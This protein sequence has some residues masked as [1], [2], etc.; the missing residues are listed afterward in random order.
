MFLTQMP[1]NPQ[2]RTTRELVSSPQRMHAAV[3]SGFLPGTAERERVLWRLDESDR[4]TLNLFIVSATEPSLEAM[5]EQAGWQTQPVWRSADYRRFLERLEGGQRWVFRLRANPVISVRPANGGRG[6]RVPLARVT[7]QEAWLLE[8]APRLGFTV[9]EGDQGRPNLQVSDR[10]RDAFRRG[11]GPDARTVTLATARFDGVLEV[12]D[13]SALR[14]T[15]VQ[16]VGS[17]KGYGCGL[18][19]LA[20]IP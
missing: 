10:R 17:A 15:L 13:P 20:R 8:R 12:S 4:H 11:W 14:S 1:L 18:M 3:L 2:R 7:E 5:V 19:T 6:Q 16:G 9:V